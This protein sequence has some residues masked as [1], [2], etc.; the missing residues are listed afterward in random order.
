[1]NL[2]GA[3]TGDHIV[4]GTGVTF[5]NA[6]NT[7]G[8]IEIDTSPSG[9]G[10]MVAML[11]SGADTVIGG[12]GTSFI[13]A[14]TG[15]DVFGF[16]NGHAGGTEYIFGFNPQDNMIFSGYTTPPTE[17]VLGGSDEIKLGDGTTIVL[18]GVGH[19]LF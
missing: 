7:T 6:T 12:G 18:I 17:Q 1:M 10:T 8:S 15:P 3:S 5:V 13:Q 14:G 9:K 2:S 11:G 16:V 19:K 4:G